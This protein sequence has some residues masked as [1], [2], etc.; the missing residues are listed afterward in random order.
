MFST[1]ACL[2]HDQTLLHDQAQHFK[3]LLHLLETSRWGI[4]AAVN[5]DVHGLLPRRCSVSVNP[6]ATP[7]EGESLLVSSWI[8][9]VFEQ[10]A[11]PDATAF[12]PS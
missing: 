6:R 8:S 4:Y 3:G 12:S 11:F 9:G 1:V 7:Q 10:G 5:D 2:R